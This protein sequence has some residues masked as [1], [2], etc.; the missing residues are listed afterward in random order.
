MSNDTLPVDEALLEAE[1]HARNGEIELAEQVYRSVLKRSPGDP[2]AVEGLNALKGGPA[3]KQADGPP[4]QDRIDGLI[5]L[6][7]QGRLQELQAQA[8]TLA[9]QYPDTGFLHYVLG[10]ANAG[11]GRLDEAVASYAQALR[12]KPDYAEAHCNLANALK[13]LGR[14]EEAVASYNAAVRIKP[15]FAEAHY[16]LGITLNDLGRHDDAVA[17]YAQALR[18]RPDFAEAHNNLGKALHDLGRREEAV[19][20]YTRALQIDPGYGDAHCNLGSALNDLGQ[21]D[22]AI[23][24]FT[25]ALR[26][27]P[28]FA[29]AHNSLGVVLNAQGKR[30]QAAASFTRALQIKPD[31]ADAYLNKSLASLEMDDFGSGWEERDW[32]ELSKTPASGP[33]F[34]LPRWVGSEDSADETARD[35]AATGMLENSPENRDHARALHKAGR[36]DAARAVCEAMLAAAPDDPDVLGLSGAID[37]QRG[38]LKEAEALFRRGL[39]TV[40]EPRIQVRNLNGLGVLLRSTGRTGEARSLAVARAPDWPEDCPAAPDERDAVVWVAEMLVDAEDAGR[41]RRFLDRA[42]PD[43]FGDADAM[44]LDGRLALKEGSPERAVEILTLAA[45]LA[46]TDPRLHI[47]LSYA[48]KQ[49][50]DGA[51]AIAT[52][53]TIA[54]TWPAYA[55]PPRSSHRATLLVFNRAPNYVTNPNETLRTVHF[56]GNYAG[57]IS[58]TMKFDY[59]FLSLFADLPDDILPIDESR[60]RLPRANVILNNLANSEKMNAPGRH[61]TVCARLDRFDLPVINH[62]EQVFQTTRVKNAALL[63]GIPNLKVPRIELF[64]IDQAS[65]DA[66]VADVGQRFDYPLIV[67]KTTV[68]Q[69]SSS[70]ENVAALLAD[71]AAL[72]DHIERSGWPEFYALEFVDLKREDGLYRKIRVVY[73]D[74]EVIVPRLGMFPGWM[75]SD[76]RSDA[77]GIEFYRANPHAVEECNRIARDPEGQLGA[78]VM[79]T[80][81]TIRDRMPLDMF[82]MDFDVDRDGRVVFFEAGASMVFQPRF[83]TEPADIR[84]PLEPFMRVDDAFHALVARRIAEGPRRAT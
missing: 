68:H 36:T 34:A 83:A 16:N 35:P 74:R 6:F 59:R 13:A 75:V 38:Q 5:A 64:R 20:S 62:P 81:E 7:N 9:G 70:N 67:R 29:D 50:G 77:D 66:I 79:R 80:L 17:S 22:E 60:D 18:I 63:A 71:P 51:A 2:R 12:I 53:R 41:A 30:E 24:S 65:P 84:L 57:Q 73:V 72:R 40:A 44:L 76:R 46:P 56:M 48:L 11:L 49:S 42:M 14:C 78:E 26:V 4:P 37:L 61:E 39:A 3:A 31:F 43:R 10:V 52:A 32:R 15:G 58:S 47:A 33:S 21:H 19:A 69:S 27:R 28:D 55:D 1:H 25:E 82:G 8:E 54:N 23:A 45:K